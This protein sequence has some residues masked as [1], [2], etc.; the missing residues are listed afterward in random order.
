MR[1][2]Q[3]G[4]LLELVREDPASFGIS[5]SFVKKNTFSLESSDFTY[6]D[7]IEHL[8]NALS[9][10]TYPEKPPNLPSTGYTTTKDVG[11]ISH[12]RFIDSP[13][14]Y[15]GRILSMACT[16]DE[17][18]LHTTIRNF[19]KMHNNCGVLEVRRNSK[20]EYQIFRGNEVYLPVFEAELLFT[21]L[22]DCVIE[23]ANYLAQPT[24]E[25]WD[26]KAVTRLVA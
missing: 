25:H 21:A 7:F 2:H 10:P 23:L 19:S 4:I 26:G 9:H 22:K 3:K 8:R 12:F 11:I 13:W 20:G 18:K 6:G 5:H 1:E 14:V 15:R 24:R 16:N 17:K